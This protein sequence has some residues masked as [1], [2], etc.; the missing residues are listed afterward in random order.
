MMRGISARKPRSRL[1]KFG[2]IVAGIT[3]I[4]A[5]VLLLMMG[6]L[7]VIKILGMT[8][9][10]EAPGLIVV[11]LAFVVFF[12]GG[13]PVSGGDDDDP[14]SHLPMGRA[15]HRYDTDGDGVIDSSDFHDDDDD[16]NDDDD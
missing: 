9:P 10:P 16:N 7:L 6:E 8:M 15:D 13:G 1:A 4:L 5:G 12:M 2:F 3:L 14:E 11:A